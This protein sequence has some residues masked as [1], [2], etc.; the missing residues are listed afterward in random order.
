MLKALFLLMTFSIGLAHGARVT[1]IEGST[2]YFKQKVAESLQ[3]LPADFLNS[4]KHRVEF[5]E[6][7]FDSDKHLSNNLCE[8]N[9]KVKFGAT[10]RRWR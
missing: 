7:N 1:F 9:E 3:L 5:S 2:D 8:L 6:V 4:A 10:K